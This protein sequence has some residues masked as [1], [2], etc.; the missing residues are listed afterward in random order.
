ML[1]GLT[2]NLK[3]QLDWKAEM[4]SIKNLWNNSELNFPATKFNTVIGYTFNKGI[5]E[6]GYGEVHSVIDKDGNVIESV[7]AKTFKLNQPQI[8]RLLLI[9]NDTNTFRWG[10]SGCF[11]PH[12]SFVFYDSENQVTN[13]IDICLLCSQTD[14]MKYSP[15]MRYGALHPK[16]REKMKQFFLDIGMPIEG[17]R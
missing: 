6:E 5:H 10:E 9:L 1:I 11:I 16:G 8:D 7:S 2:V 12:H 3:A 15:K 13:C 17:N 14:A 4:D